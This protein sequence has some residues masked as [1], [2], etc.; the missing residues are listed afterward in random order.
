MLPRQQLSTSTEKKHLVSSSSDITD[1][2]PFMVW[3]AEDKELNLFCGPDKI[4][5]LNHLQEYIYNAAYTDN[6][7]EGT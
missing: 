4:S 3:Y 6:E 1:S 2:A 7:K 5:K